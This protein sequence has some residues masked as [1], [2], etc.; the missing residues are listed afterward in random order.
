MTESLAVPE[1]GIDHPVYHKFKKY[2]FYFIAICFLYTFYCVVTV[3]GDFTESGRFDGGERMN[4][5]GNFSFSGT[6][7]L[8]G[9][10]PTFKIGSVREDRIREEHTNKDLG[11]EEFSKQER[12]L[13]RT[14]LF[15]RMPYILLLIGIG[16]Y[17][18]S[19]YHRDRQTAFV[20]GSIGTVMSFFS[21]ISILWVFHDFEK[22]ADTVQKVA[23]MFGQG[24]SVNVESSGSLGVWGLIIAFGALL[25][26]YL[27]INLGRFPAMIRGIEFNKAKTITNDQ[28]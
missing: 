8:F 3:T 13:M 6:Q 9:Q 22:I 14:P 7:L 2:I 4:G 17:A 25:V 18:W 27:I 23:F 12:K 19:V 26:D 11:K 10:M 21:A 5:Y 24:I 1:P 28:E 15:F 20:M 16:L